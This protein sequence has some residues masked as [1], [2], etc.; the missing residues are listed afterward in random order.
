MPRPDA[1]KVLNLQHSGGTSQCQELQFWWGGE[2]YKVYS[3]YFNILRFIA[4]F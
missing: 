4:V 2:Q 3:L 1:G